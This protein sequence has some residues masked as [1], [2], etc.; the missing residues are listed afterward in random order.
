MKM[1]SEKIS[2]SCLRGHAHNSNVMSGMNFKKLRKHIE[3]SGMYPP[4][5]VRPMG[6]GDVYEI[7]DGHHRFKVLKSLGYKE[8]RCEIW[9][10]DEA[11]GLILMATLNRLEG[12]DDPILRGEL[13]RE[14]GRFV[15]C[16][17]LL[18]MLPDPSSR[19]SELVGLLKPVA[20]ICEPV[21]LEELP[22]ALHFFLFP[23]ELRLVRKR[24]GEEGGTME[25]GL[26]RI[27]GIDR[28]KDLRS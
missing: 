9:D 22:C 26:L 25:E 3:G 10:V 6:E 17:K 27:L 4:L 13:L 5:I 14:L 19:V 2:L 28:V 11:G 8:A 18:E 23:N 24:L 12:V 15:P 1:Q 21:V 7:L 16:E 20:E